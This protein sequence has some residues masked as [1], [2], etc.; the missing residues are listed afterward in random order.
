MMGNWCRTLWQEARRPC[1]A[2]KE[3]PFFA[4]HGNESMF[5]NF[6]RT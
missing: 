1:D 4:L 5:D 2:Q 3:S 6:F